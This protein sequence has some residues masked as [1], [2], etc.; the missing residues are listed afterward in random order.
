MK[1]V[2]ALAL[3]LAGGQLAAGGWQPVHASPGVKPAPQAK[4]AG[5]GALMPPDS[6]V[7]GWKRA[8]TSRVFTKADLYGYIDGGAEVFL[9]FGFDQLTLQKYRNR[10]SEMAVEIYR[11]SDPVAST[12][13]YLMKC[14]KETRDP[15][16]K[17]RHTLNR[18][19]LMFV[20]SRYYV[21][22]NNLSGADGMGRA[23]LAFGAAVAGSLPPDR[24]PS[25]LGLPAQAQV[26]GTLR[27]VRGPFSLQ[28]IY[29]LG[30]GDILQMG[31]RVVGAAANYKDAGGAYTLLVVPYATPAAAKAAFGSV[32]KNL[33]KY[34]KPVTSTP[35][36]LVFKDYENKFG[37]VSVTGPKV[38]VKLHLTKEPQ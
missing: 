18:H 34:L 10:A 20:R 3:I 1:K 11:M 15:S 17:E 35:T 36:R 16:F 7:A 25:T 6:A 2:L 21:T 38:E 8:E 33:D 37:T 27:F 13:I 22:I 31:G 19:Q 23:L 29:T 26:Q 28:S 24:P 14:G 9:E 12:G 30:D 32:Q 4:P 5:D